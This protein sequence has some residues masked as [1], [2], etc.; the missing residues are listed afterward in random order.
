MRVHACVH[1]LC[2]R[3]HASGCLT[4]M[5]G[6]TYA[7][8]YVHMYAYVCICVYGIRC[9]QYF[10]FKTMIEASTS[11]KKC[12]HRSLLYSF[13]IYQYIPILIINHLIQWN[14]AWY[15]R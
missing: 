15:F 3:V 2:L 14:K 5:G 8:I 10:D 6:P 11:D 13:I 7:H 1:T 4:S 9:K 12:L